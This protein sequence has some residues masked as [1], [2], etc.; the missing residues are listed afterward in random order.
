MCLYDSVAVISAIVGLVVLVNYD[1]RERRT[2]RKKT[3]TDRRNTFG[4]S[5]R[6]KVTAATK[7]IAFYTRN[8]VTNSD[9]N[10]AATIRVFATYC[11]SVI[12]S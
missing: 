5:Y 10:K 7:G 3:G 1:G 4:Y 12:F 11:V 2:T 6:R 8:G 9:G